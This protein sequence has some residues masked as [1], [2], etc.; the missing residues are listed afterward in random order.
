MTLSTF[1]RTLLTVGALALPNAFGFSAGPQALRAGVPGDVAS[2][3]AVG[4]TCTACHRTYSLNPDTLGR[5]TV[6]A[7]DYVPGVKQ[8][9]KVRVEH[10][11]GMRWGFELTAR[12]ASND[13]VMAGSFTASD[14]VRV[15]CATGPVPC[16]T[17]WFATHNAASNRAGTPNGVEWE[18]EWTPPA[19]EIGDVIFYVAGNAANND[20][21]LNGDRIYNSQLRVKAGGACSLTKKPTLRSL[22][23]AATF[24]LTLAPNSMASVFGLDFQ[25]AGNSRIAG[26][27]DFVNGAFP[28]QLGCVAVEVAGQRA[29][30]TY[31]QNDQ[32]N[33]Q[34]PTISQTGPVPVTII[35][36][37]GQPNEVRSDVGTATMAAYSP[38]FFTF[39]GRSIAATS[40]DGRTLVA[41]ASVIP[42]GVPAK[43]GDVIVLY[44]T[45]F[46]LS[47]PVYQ[48]GEIVAGQAKLRDAFT[49]SVGG[50]LL[51]AA[52]ILYAGLAPSSISGLYQFNVRLPLSLAD[53]D[54][55]VV[56]TMGGVASPA[57][58]TIPIKR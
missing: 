39:N 24:A 34:V 20:G 41:A 9:V 57:S 11:E 18:V 50:T 13:Q 10:P 33:F 43:P 16:S 22:S 19:S 40:A 36:N 44:G 32:I 15:V 2:N 48:S 46:G 56:V 45:G 23:N 1:T 47:D 28:K 5:V 49:I 25:I 31:V 14:S 12:S 8:T 27:G 52:D 26:S 29:P 6:T 51:A 53:G 3:G 38:G 58:A 37:P 42:S 30:V 7:T 17:L 55:P 54:I 21:T 4:T 35:L